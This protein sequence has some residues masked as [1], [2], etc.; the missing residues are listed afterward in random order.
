MT[1]SKVQSQLSWKSATATQSDRLTIHVGTL[2]NPLYCLP[3]LTG[4]SHAS[5]KEHV[6]RKAFLNLWVQEGHQWGRECTR[7]N[8]DHAD[9]MGF[10]V[11]G[12]GEGHTDECTL[13]GSVRNLTSLSFTKLRRE[14]ETQFLSKRG[15]I[16]SRA[17]RTAAVLAT[18]TTTPLSPSGP[19]EGTVTR[20]LQTTRVRLN[21]P[22]RL[23]SIVKCHT[24]RGWG[25]PS[26]PIIYV[27]QLVLY[28]SVK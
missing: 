20:Y 7:R 8:G 9:A 11:T 10:E 13:G 16:K 15:E 17:E 14:R 18:M 6:M 4:L 25:C 23:T 28:V 12:H 24:S 19:S 1:R 2:Q 3:K 27:G 22:V 5:W 26:V 21:V